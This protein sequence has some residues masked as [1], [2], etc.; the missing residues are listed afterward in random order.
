[1]SR[2]SAR[3]GTA[4]LAILV[5]SILGLAACSEPVNDRSVSFSPPAG[6]DRVTTPGTVFDPAM[7]EALAG[8]LAVA[9]EGSDW[10][11]GWDVAIDNAGTA[12]YEYGSN[13]GVGRTATTCANWVVVAADIAWVS[14]SSESNDAAGIDV[15]SSDAALAERLRSE[16]DVLNGAASS[17]I[18]GDD[19]DT[20]IANAVSSVALALGAE[21]ELEAIGV[22]ATDAED[23]VAFEDSEG[24]GGNDAFAQNRN[25]IVFGA[26]LLVLGLFLLVRSLRRRRGAGAR[27]ASAAPSGGN[28]RVALR[29]A[30]ERRQAPPLPAA[31]RRVRRPVQPPR[32]T[33]GG[34]RRPGRRHVRTASPAPRGTT[35]MNPLL[36]AVTTDGVLATLAYAALGATMLVLGS[37]AVDLV[38]PGKL[39]EL[40]RRGSPNAAA[41]IVANLVAVA[42]IVFGAGMTADD[43]TWDGLGSMA[44]YGS[45]GIAA[46]ALLLF[47]IDNL[48]KID[49]DEVLPDLRLQPAAVVAATASVALGSTMVVA[50]V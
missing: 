47:V 41:L 34:A 13:L 10:C 46:Q 15:F 42:M 33:P 44:L 27:S 45:I 25:R 22:T 23:G 39:F 9:V 36:A 50:V 40:L 30:L 37:V 32:R 11:I 2:S 26:V 38:T 49:F 18:A 8:E 19:G 43:S 4:A 12:V 5:A 24:E 21:G 14:S 6:D 7:A 1:M 20:T 3:R 28:P 29:E 35:P 48:M 16:H 31:A 17:E